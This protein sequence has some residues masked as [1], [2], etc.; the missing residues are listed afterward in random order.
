MKV[1]PP[2]N[3]TKRAQFQL[4][5][6]LEPP[7]PRNSDDE[8]IKPIAFTCKMNPKDKNSSE[9]VIKVYKVGDDTTVENLLETFKQMVAVEAGQA[10]KKNEDRVTLVRQL[11][12][13]SLLTAFENELPGLDASNKPITIENGHYDAGIEAI[14][15]V[16]F[17]DKAAR[18]HKKAMRKV[19]LP[20]NM[21]FRVFANRFKKQNDFLPFF[22]LL[23]N[24]TKPTPLAEE[25]LLECLHDALP[26]E[27]FRER[28]Q[29]QGYDPTTDTFHN[30]IQ[31]VEERCEPFMRPPKNRSTG[32]VPIPKKKRKPDNQSG[33]KT[34]HDSSNKKQRKFC[35]YH[36]YCDHTTDECKVVKS[37]LSKVA[38][39]NKSDKS[40]DFHA[41]LTS[42]DFQLMQDKRTA[43]ICS[44]LFKAFKND[45][46]EEFHLMER[47]PV[48]DNVNENENDAYINALKLNQADDGSAKCPSDEELIDSVDESGLDDID[49]QKL[50]SGY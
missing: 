19:K 4:C 23:A 7:P 42:Q 15:K 17:P 28:I 3:K 6:P 21:K 33:G 29:A 22:P 12:E 41:M 40:K 44:K 45:I 43:S 8:V 39:Y 50:L 37:S 13:G 26:W 18:N 25:E 1:V 20:L 24:G 48:K 27:N 35:L 31:W 30:F 34:H 38:Q 16:V 14:K 11:F 46:K 47:S 32:D 9:F 5:I 2:Q 36:K 10:L 49:V